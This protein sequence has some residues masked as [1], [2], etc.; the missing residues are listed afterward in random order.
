MKSGI[1]W[2]R[3]GFAAAC[4]TAVTGCG[5]SH[6]NASS[7]ATRTRQTSSYGVRTLPAGY[8]PGG[9]VQITIAV[10]PPSGAVAYAVEDTVPS[11][12]T[13]ATADNSGAYESANSKVKWA[14]MD[15]NARTLHYTLNIPS[16]ASGDQTLAG[17]VSLSGQSTAI[18][19][20]TVLKSSGAAHPADTNGDS[21]ISINE[22][23]TYITGWKSGQSDSIDL[24][25]N[26]I[27]LWKNGEWYH[28]DATVNPPYVTG[29]PAGRGPGSLV[30]TIAPAEVLA[31]GARW[32]LDNDTTEHPSG[33]TISSL[34]SGTHTVK[35]TTVSGYLT[36]STQSVTVNVG[37][38]TALTGTYMTLST[39]SPPPPPSFRR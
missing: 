29:A 9:T 25:T 37:Q 24:V 38:L 12:W 14:F 18:G 1:R 30:V 33:E 3:I 23:T 10:T 39:I 7:T 34:P 6:G 11:G 32:L 2:W 22:M 26:A 4:L 13:L 35:F 28:Y 21:T 16:S 19:G 8:T 36:P 17:V 27:A 5:G 15:G 20:D 31:A